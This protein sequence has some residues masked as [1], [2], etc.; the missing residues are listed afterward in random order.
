MYLASD[1]L[2]RT[3][4]VPYSCGIRPATVRLAAAAPSADSGDQLLQSESGLEP[5]PTVRYPG[6]GRSGRHPKPAR[7]DP[8]YSGLRSDSCARCMHCRAVTGGRPGSV[9]L[10]GWHRLLEFLYA[11]SE[12]ATLRQK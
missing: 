2:P 3:D 8:A 11:G 7:G 5:E 10:P 12:R 9:A 4:S 6:G 1:W